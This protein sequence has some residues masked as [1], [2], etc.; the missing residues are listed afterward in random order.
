LNI[1]QINLLTYQGYSVVELE[2][3]MEEILKNPY[4][5]K[6]INEIQNN[7]IN[8]Q[9]LTSKDVQDFVKRKLT[10]DIIK[11]ISPKELKSLVIILGVFLET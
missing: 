3:R 4:I 6:L 7:L 8:R 10:L 9:N 11:N 1:N 5:E 2:R